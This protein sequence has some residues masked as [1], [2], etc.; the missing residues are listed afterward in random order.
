MEEVYRAFRCLCPT[1]ALNYKECEQLLNLSEATFT[2]WDHDSNGLIDA[3]E[4]FSVLALYSS[5]LTEDKI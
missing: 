5:A 3:M 2:L 1:Y 4:L